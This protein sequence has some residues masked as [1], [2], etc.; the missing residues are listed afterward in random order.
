MHIGIPFSGII[1][2]QEGEGGKPNYYRGLSMTESDGVRAVSFQEQKESSPALPEFPTGERGG[3][4][5][6]LLRKNSD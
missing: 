1:I 5:V 3:G 2:V 6:K 4:W